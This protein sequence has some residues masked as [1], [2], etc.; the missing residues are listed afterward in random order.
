M[1]TLENVDRIIPNVLS[2]LIAN[3]NLLKC[4]KYPTKDALYKNDLTQVEI[5]SLFDNNDANEIRISFTPFNLTTA[6]QDK[7]EIRIF[8]KQFT[9]ENIHLANLSLAIQVIVSNNIWLM[10][11]GRMRPSVLIQEILKELNG[12]DVNLVGLL[13]F[14]SPI[15]VY[16]YNTYFSGYELYPEVR[17]V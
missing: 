7:S 16:N 9:P 15:R 12:T 8:I 17:S 13:Y 6:D 4:L 11:D 10:D 3:Q 5:N 2:K 1:F 14:D